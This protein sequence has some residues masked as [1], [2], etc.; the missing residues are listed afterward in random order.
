MT[1]KSHEII[2]YT[3]HFVN[4][5][6]CFQHTF[7]P[8]LNLTCLFLL[9]L[10]PKNRRGKKIFLSI[11]LYKTTFHAVR[12]MDLNKIKF[13]NLYVPKIFFSKLKCSTHF[14]VENNDDYLLPK[15]R[16]WK[17]NY[18]VLRSIFLEIHVLF[19][20]FISHKSWWGSILYFC[21]R[22]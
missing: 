3:F 20:L 16:P 6:Y 14:K 22:V 15:F 11:W 12:P 4:T 17:V 7:S 19:Y 18:L 1:L 13:K 5:L 21:R 10:T 8:N 2:R 9:E